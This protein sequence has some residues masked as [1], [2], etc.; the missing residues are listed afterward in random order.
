ML[1]ERTTEFISQFVNEQARR[2]AKFCAQV[3]GR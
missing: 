1:D 3:D 2:P